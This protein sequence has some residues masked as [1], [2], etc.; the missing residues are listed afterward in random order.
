MEDAN[1]L[2]S[3]WLFL[4]AHHQP[5]SPAGEGAFVTPDSIL[6][7]NHYVGTKIV[8]AEHSCIEPAKELACFHYSRGGV[9]PVTDLELALH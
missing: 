3:S 7:W 9:T 4:P 5:L 8:F 6:D 1:G 2:F